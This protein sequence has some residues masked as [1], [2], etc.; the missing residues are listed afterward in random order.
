MY[1]ATAYYKEERDWDMLLNHY[2]DVLYDWQR[3]VQ[4]LRG[5]GFAVEI[6]ATHDKSKG[7]IDP[8]RAS[9]ISP[10]IYE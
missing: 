2:Y 10:K 1:H 7:E 5:K 6:T 3:E 4:S 9:P 8:P